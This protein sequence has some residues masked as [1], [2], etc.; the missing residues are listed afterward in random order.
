MDSKELI[1]E[2]LSR[3]IRI[4]IDNNIP[5]SEIMDEITD[6]QVWVIERKYVTAIEFLKIVTESIG[7]DIPVKQ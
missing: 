7:N 5:M 1:R 3:I 4:C 6:F 2:T